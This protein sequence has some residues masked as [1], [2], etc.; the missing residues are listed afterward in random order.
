[1]SFKDEMKELMSPP[2]IKAYR[3]ERLDSL[4]YANFAEQV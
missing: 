2:D 4:I 3:D 1:M